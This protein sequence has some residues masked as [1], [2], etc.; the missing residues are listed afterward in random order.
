M[1][2]RKAFCCMCIILM[3]AL[4]SSGAPKAFAAKEVKVGLFPFGPGRMIDE[5]IGDEGIAKKWGAEVGVD[6][7][8]SHP[9]DDFA[10]FMGKSIDI[11][12]LSTLEIG[13][14]VG[15]EGHD[16]IMWGRQ[17]DAFIDMYV[18]GDSPYKTPA[19]LKGKKIVHPGWDTGTA[20]MGTVLLKEWYGLDM[21]KDF[22][23]VTAPWPVGPQLLAKGDVEMSLNL[24]PLTMDLWRGGKIR[25]VLATYAT[26]WAKKRGVDH[27]LSIT[28]F[29]AWGKWL[30][31]NEGAARAWLGVYSEGMKYAREKTAEWASRYRNYITKNA[32]DEQVAFF[33]KW[34]K[35]YGVVY[36]NAYLSQR[37]IDE[38]TAFLKMANRAGFVKPAGLKPEIWRIIKP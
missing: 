32:T 9:R 35:K 36:E 8:I 19:D 26:V 15:D 21:K 20:Q 16:I 13:R 1:S 33:V 37:F 10:A 18:R 27:H 11:V 14:L 24:M 31:A 12:A 2:I 23:V 28:N 6:F 38:E 34:F 29:T 7:K 30:K 25:P 4:M 17:V 5:Y 3:A 22:K